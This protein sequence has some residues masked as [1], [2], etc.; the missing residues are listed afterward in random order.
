MTLTKPWMSSSS[1]MTRQI[2]REPM[3]PL[4]IAS[5][6]RRSSVRF[7]DETFPVI[8]VGG[9]FA[10]VT[11]ATQLGLKGIDVLLTDKNN[12]H[13]FQPLLSRR[14]RGHFGPSSAARTGSG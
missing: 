10:G 4:P 6:G 3:D 9:G 11:T 13:Q 2:P 1:S 7:M 5:V 12:Y 14:W 8:V